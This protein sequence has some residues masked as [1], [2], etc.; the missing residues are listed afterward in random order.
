MLFYKALFFVVL[1]CKYLPTFKPITVKHKI[2]QTKN[3]FRVALLLFA[4][5]SFAQST[6]IEAKD[7]IHYITN[8]ID[9]PVT[10]TYLYQ[11]QEPVVE[12]NDKGLGIYQLHDQP[13]RAMVWGIECDEA[14]APKFK[15]GFDSAAY[16]LWYQ[17]TAKSED[18]EDEM[19]WTPVEFT[20]HFNTLKMFIQGE[21]SKSYTEPK[22]Y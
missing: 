4:L 14:R 2:M 19:V 21:R 12:L 7:G 17:F 18:T 8:N 15:K 20:I 5:N 22:R 9:Y 6:K 13:K 11:G 16:T 3:L 1:L 10:G